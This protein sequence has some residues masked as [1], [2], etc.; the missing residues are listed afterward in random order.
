M[1]IRTMTTAIKSIADLQRAQVAYGVG[2]ATKAR[3]MH[4]T[5]VLDRLRGLSKDFVENRPE[6]PEEA[7]EILDV[8]EGES[9]RGKFKGLSK[10]FRRV[11]SER[12]PLSDEETAVMSINR[13]YIIL[14]R[15]QKS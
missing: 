4:V 8:S 12:G 3:N 2:S 7:R 13:A 10:I 14:F 5:G 9:Y 1:K 11:H 15:S 6:T